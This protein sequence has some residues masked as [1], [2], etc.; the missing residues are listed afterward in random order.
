MAISLYFTIFFHFIELSKWSYLQTKP[1]VRLIAM[2]MDYD[3]RFLYRGQT[4]GNTARWGGGVTKCHTDNLNHSIRE[5]VTA[6]PLPLPHPYSP[7]LPPP[8]AQVFSFQHREKKN[9]NLRL[10]HNL[11][12]CMSHLRRVSAAI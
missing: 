8:S 5:R 11:S 2:Q 6:I 4:S 10:R 12:L 1:T 7:K 3:F 9:R